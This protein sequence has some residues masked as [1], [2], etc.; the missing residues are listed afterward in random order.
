MHLPTGCK[1]LTAVGWFCRP[2]QEVLCAVEG[3]VEGQEKVP[4]LSLTAYMFLLSDR[5]V[6]DCVLLSLCRLVDQA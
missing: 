1:L 2:S 6:F 4:C 5:A 3:N